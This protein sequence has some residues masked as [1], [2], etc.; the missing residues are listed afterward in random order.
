M[1]T[2]S[3]TS[4][5]LVTDVSLYC[6]S[7]NRFK[8]RHGYG[9]QVFPDGAVYIGLWNDDQMTEGQLIDSGGNIWSGN[10]STRK[11]MKETPAPAAANKVHIDNTADNDLTTVTSTSDQSR[12]QIEAVESEE[13]Q[14]QQFQIQTQPADSASTQP[15]PAHTNTNSVAA[16][17]IKVHATHN[18]TTA[19]AST[20]TNITLPTRP[21]SPELSKFLL[22]QLLSSPLYHNTLHSSHTSSSSHSSRSSFQRSTAVSPGPAQYTPRLPKSTQTATIKSRIGSF[23]D[24][25]LKTSISPGP[26]AS[27]HSDK[28]YSVSESHN[29]RP[30]FSY[31]GRAE[32]EK[33]SETPAA[34]NYTVTCDQYGK[35]FHT[36]SGPTF[37]PNSTNDYV[38]SLPSKHK[39]D[40]SPGPGTYTLPSSLSFN[41]THITNSTTH[42]PGFK[43]TARRLSGSELDHIRELKETAQRHSQDLAK[44]PIILPPSLLSNNDVLNSR[45]AGRSG[46]KKGFNMRG[47][48]LQRDYQGYE[49][50]YSGMGDTRYISEQHSRIARFGGHRVR[51]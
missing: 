51:G 11:L 7:L 34:A 6:G 9:R 50:S 1:T 10:F 44:L 31:S 35:S 49:Y 37:T 46:G 28:L 32:L 45:S 18:N 25:E 21:S 14:L 48:G 4:S 42:R 8:H 43:F 26:G 16:H 38:I 40:R 33:V 24:K 3:P 22:T 23:L 15:A 27:T 47:G 36:V 5:L 12:D 29:I 13:K 39:T 19:I 41:S 2:S 20:T 17:S 30:S